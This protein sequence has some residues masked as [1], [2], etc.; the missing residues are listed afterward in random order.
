MIKGRLPLFLK[1]LFIMKMSTKFDAIKELYGIVTLTIQHQPDL[2]RTIFLLNFVS[3]VPIY[4]RDT[5]LTY[6]DIN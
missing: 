5:V 4:K 2:V 3:T 1:A 6:E